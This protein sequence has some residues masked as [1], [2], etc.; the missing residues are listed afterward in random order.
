[1]VDCAR[2]Q[3]RFMSEADGGLYVDSAE[4]LLQSAVLRTLRRKL[5]E[6]TEE[7]TEGC[8]CVLVKPSMLLHTPSVFVLSFFVL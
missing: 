7:M 1:M 2:S 4:V 3:R 8:S 6:V 5:R